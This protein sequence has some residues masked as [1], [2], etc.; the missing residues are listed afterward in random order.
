MLEQALKD[1]RTY[2]VTGDR[3]TLWWT[4]GGHPLGSHV[5]TPTE[6]HA[7]VHIDCPLPL[8]RVEMLHNGEVAEVYTHQDK[9][10]NEDSGKYRLLVE[11]GWGPTPDYGDFDKTEFE[12]SG[13]IRASE[14]TLTNIQPRF[15]G[16][17]QEYRFDDGTCTFDL[18]TS[19]D[20]QNYLLPEGDAD[21]TKQGFIIEVEG[22]DQTSII[23][24]VDGEE[25][26]VPLASA[27]SKDHLFALTEESL[28][29]LDAEFEL[30]QEDIDNPDI[31]YHNSR[32]IQVGRAH[33]AASCQAAIEFDDLP[34]SNGEDYYYVRAAQQNGQFAWASPI[35]IDD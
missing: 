32:K 27:R 30:Q 20:T 18:V 1:R 13:T 2:G 16:F 10:Q 35:W 15:K 8:D 28:D 9:S 17:G 31:V 26:E 33:P 19:R 24:D 23:I 6:R 5:T 3:M 22:S 7:S 21:R 14:G 29:R 4:M 34:S 12:W 25:V 11:F